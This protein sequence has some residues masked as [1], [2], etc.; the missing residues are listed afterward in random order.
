MMLPIL[1]FVAQKKEAN[2]KE[3]AKFIIEYFKLSDDEIL[4]KIKSG[5][6]TYI[7]RTGWALSYLATT[8]QI[9]SRPEKVPLQKVGRSLFAI[10]NFGKELVS[11]K[12]KKS[13]FLTWYDEIYK[14]EI[15]QEKKEATENTPDDNID[16]ALCKIKEELKSEILSSILE[17]EPR[18]FEYLVTKLLEK[19]NYGAGNLTN[20]GQTAG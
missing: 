1:E 18:F 6:F 7:S 16:E 14:Q 11:S 9:K 10:T 17:K 4:Q 19:M 8:A 15:R 20:K 5:T 13:K 3:I 12:D 2:T